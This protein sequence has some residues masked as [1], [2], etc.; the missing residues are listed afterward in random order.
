V[1]PVT[2]EDSAGLNA[3]RC[4]AEFRRTTTAAQETAS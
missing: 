3:L 1:I 4:A 2:A